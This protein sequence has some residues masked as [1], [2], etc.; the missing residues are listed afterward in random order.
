MKSFHLTPGDKNSWFIR[1]KF[2]TAFLLIMT[3]GIIS[4]A[5]NPKTSNQTS[6]IQ[7]QPQKLPQTQR[8]LSFTY[9][10]IKSW[11]IPNGGQGKV[12]V[13]D[14][15]WFKDRQMKLVSDK[16]HADTKNERNAFVFVFTDVKAAN[17]R[18][19]ASGGQLNQA[20]QDYYDDHYAGQYTKNINSGLDEFAVY[21]DGLLNGSSETF[22]Y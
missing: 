9:Q 1:H 12:V 5:L 21:Y 13:I 7:K 22:E 4:A 15:K 3:I 16:I 20:D 2:T 14:P 6:Q 11:E 8:K 19:A 10:I 18:D 17:M